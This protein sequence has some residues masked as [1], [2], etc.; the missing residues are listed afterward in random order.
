MLDSF[1]SLQLGVD[2]GG[3]GSYSSSQLRDRVHFPDKANP[4][5]TSCGDR[6]R[7]I[8]CTG[9]PGFATEWASGSSGFR[10]SRRRGPRTTVK[11]RL[12]PR[13]RSGLVE[14]RTFRT[15]LFVSHGCYL[16]FEFRG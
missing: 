4:K 13:L 3:G 12:A 9:A 8:V 7:F 15:V 11:P 5:H 16:I 10:L 1:L 2:F 6:V 14:T